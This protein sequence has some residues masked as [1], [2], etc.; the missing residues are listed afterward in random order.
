V[1]SESDSAS[2][3][4]RLPPKS[5]IGIFAMMAFSICST[6]VLI[7]ML[8]DTRGLSSRLSCGVLP[9][10][11]APCNCH[12]ARPL[13]A[14]LRCPRPMVSRLRAS[15]KLVFESEECMAV[16]IISLTEIRAAMFTQVV[17]DATSHCRRCSLVSE[18]RSPD[19]SILFQ[20]GRH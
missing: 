6:W 14:Q 8:T 20:A 1:K 19:S 15:S 12:F 3:S 7:R 9:Q 16:F 10:S 4:L 13:P 18:P 17:I 11:A 5:A 2:D